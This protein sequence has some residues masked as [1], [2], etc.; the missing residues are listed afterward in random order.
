MKPKIDTKLLKRDSNIKEIYSVSVWNKFEKVLDESEDNT[1]QLVYDSLST[2]IDE[3]S[4]DIL[5]KATKE[6]KHPWMTE[7]IL[8]LMDD[9]R[10]AKG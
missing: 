3:A 7:A 1:I 4:T 2:A 9:R 5:P 6:P 10:E 8:T